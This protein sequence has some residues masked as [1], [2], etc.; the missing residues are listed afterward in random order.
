M[1]RFSPQLIVALVLYFIF[2]PAG[3]G[4]INLVPNGGFEEFEQL[5]AQPSDF[6]LKRWYNPSSGNSYPFGTPDYLHTKGFLQNR[7]PMSRYGIVHPQEGDGIVGLVAYS[8][9]EA[10]F[11]EYVAVEL[12]KPLLPGRKYHISFWVT[13]GER[14]HYMAGA[15]GQLGM[16][17]SPQKFN[18]KEHE[19]ISIIPQIVIWEILFE[20]GWKHI[21]GDFI[22]QEAMRHLAIGNFFSD[23]RTDY[24]SFVTDGGKGAYYFIDNV[25]V[26]EITEDPDTTPSIASTTTIDPSLILKP[27]TQA[28]LVDPTPAT[29]D[30]PQLPDPGQPGEMPRKMDGRKIQ[31][32]EVV[33]VSSAELDLNVLDSRAED[34]DVISL[35][36]NGKWLLKAY[37]IKN[38]PI[39]IHIQLEEGATNTLVFYAHNLGSTPPNTAVVSFEENGRK[40]SIVVE[41]DMK[42]CGAVTFILEEPQ[43]GK[44]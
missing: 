10:D 38:K 15:I 22:P 16:C 30:L 28:I 17:F 13:N 34:G 43:K 5:P 7:L 27:D 3:L 23:K 25:Q 9:A 20:T 35:S 33:K 26:T 41:S 39:K 19:P 1:P 8:G 32:Q 21:E 4:Q 2:P 11:R 29:S 18:Q 31:R 24:R 36:F 37:Q 40:H 6:G 14:S 42:R 44:K 12:A